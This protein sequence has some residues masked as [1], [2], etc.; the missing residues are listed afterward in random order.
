MLSHAIGTTLGRGDTDG[1]KLADYPGSL[2]M[3]LL[4]IGLLYQSD[5]I[6]AAVDRF[7]RLWLEYGEKLERVQLRASP[8]DCC[9]RQLASTSR[10]SWP[11]VLGLSPIP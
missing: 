7:S 2:V 5:D 6:F 4:R 10:R 3:E 9:A 1:R 11:W 8:R